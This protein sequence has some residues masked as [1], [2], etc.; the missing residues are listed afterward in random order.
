MCMKETS[1][2]LTMLIPGP[3]SPAKDIDVY[4]QPLIKELQ[5]LWKGV[6]TKDAATGTHFQMKAALL[7]TINDFPAR[8]SLSGWSGHK[9]RIIAE[10]DLVVKKFPENDLVVKKFPEGDRLE[11]YGIVDG[12]V[13]HKGQLV[14]PRTSS[15]I[16]QI[17]HEMHGDATRGMKRFKRCIRGCLLQPLNL[18]EQ[19]WEELSM[20]FIDGLS[21]SQGYI[22]IMV[23]VDRLSKSAHFFPLKHPYTAA[24]VAVEFIVGTQLKRSMAYHPHINGHTKMVNYSLETYLWCFLSSKPKQWVKWL[25]WVEY[26]YN[27]SFHSSIGMTPFKVL[28]GRDPPMIMRNDKGVATTFEVNRYLL[29]RDE[30]LDELKMHLRRAQQLMKIIVACRLCLKLA[31]RFYEPFKIVEVVANHL[32]L[33]P[34][35]SIHL[36]FHVSQLKVVIRDHVAALELLVGL[37]EDMAIVCKTVEVIGTGEGSEGLE[38][39]VI[40]EGLTRDK[41]TWERV[42][43]LSK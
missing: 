18:N 13:R 10:N 7:W 21:K 6:W 19:M 34:T 8:S 22:V 9:P 27:T 28:Y 11:G 16:P 15:L 17:F 29:E 39:L 1:L 20:D 12:D 14:L 2:M 33:P 24:S 23:V 42:D 35:A 26:L 37:T 25:P 40:W 41:A 3:K 31:P 32:K 5:E 43:L 36:V 30:V 38:V 4:L